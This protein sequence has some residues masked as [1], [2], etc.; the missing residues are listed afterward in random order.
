MRDIVVTIFLILLAPLAFYRPFVGLLLWT[1]ITYMSP[2]QY[3]W[4]YWARHVPQGVIVAAPTI[5]G[6]L[7]TR[8]RRRV[9][10][11]RE[12]LLLGLLWLWFGITTI[13]VWLSPFFVHHL[14]DTLIALFEVSKTLF[15]IFLATALV[16][17]RKRLHW[18]FLVTAGSIGLFAIKG[19]IFGLVSG[20]DF[21]VYGPPHSMITDNNDLALAINMC[22]PMFLYLARVER[23][24]WLR[25]FLQISFLGGVGTVIL[26]YSRGG[27]VAMLGVCCILLFQAKHKLRS[28]LAVAFMGILIFSLAPEKWFARMQT[29]PTAAHTDPSVEGRLAAWRLARLLAADHPILGGGFET[30][31]PELY[32][33]YGIL[34]NIHEL[35]WTTRATGPHSIYYEILAEQGY[36][37]LFLFLA[38]MLSCVLTCWKIKRWTRRHVSLQAWRPYCDMTIASIF[39]YAVGGAFLGRAYFPIFYQLVAATI[40]LSAAVRYELRQVTQVRVPAKFAMAD[41]GI[42]SAQEGFTQTS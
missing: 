29:I 32:E 13:H 42:V 27:L 4:S 7:L 37:G 21:R 19:T 8:Q 35:T 40:V 11:T 6:F 25:R 14:P 39:A 36:V 24:R 5:A 23:S 17:N 30:Y 20:G 33:H 18:W 41:A 16:T 2:G 28:V 1:W 3:T 15:M 26:S 12:T 9:P 34:G 31:T 38:L 10:V 22:L